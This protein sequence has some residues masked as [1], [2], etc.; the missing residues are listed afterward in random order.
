[1]S[2]SLL[3]KTLVFTQKDPLELLLMHVHVRDRLTCR[4]VGLLGWSEW[5]G[6]VGFRANLL[7]RTQAVLSLL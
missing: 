3:L 1:L 7:L 6:K 2:A 5:S 4:D